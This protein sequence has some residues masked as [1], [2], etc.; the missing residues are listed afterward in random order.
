MP[1]GFH[2]YKRQHRPA[3]RRNNVLLRWNNIYSICRPKVGLWEILPVCGRFLKTTIKRQF[4]ITSSPSS[5]SVTITLFRLSS[6]V[7]NIGSFSLAQRIPL[8]SAFMRKLV[9]L[10]NSA[11]VHSVPHWR[12][13]LVLQST[14]SL[15]CQIYL[16]IYRYS[17]CNTA[18]SPEARHSTV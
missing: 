18:S 3:P 5:W 16:I 9:N 10:G 8:P 15:R 12:N 6:S 7:F 11:S 17:V 2:T 14:S 13:K 1:L 4:H